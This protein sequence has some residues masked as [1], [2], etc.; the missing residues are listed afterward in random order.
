MPFAIA[1][2]FSDHASE[3]QKRIILSFFNAVS[4]AV[5]VIGKPTYTF[6][7]SRQS[8][9]ERTH[10]ALSEWEM[11]GLIRWRPREEE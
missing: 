6:V 9:I 3:Y 11:K 8:K 2:E 4:G 1:I 7:V 10:D 5:E